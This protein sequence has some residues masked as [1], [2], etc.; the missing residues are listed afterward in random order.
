MLAGK[1]NANSN[2]VE[3][4]D[5]LI[6]RGAIKALLYWV[7]ILREII[8]EGNIFHLISNHFSIPINFYNYCNSVGGCFSFLSTS[9]L[10]V[11]LR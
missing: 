6:V 5:V 10:F 3:E 8:K 1:I 2:K 7:A 9:S 11:I 4:P